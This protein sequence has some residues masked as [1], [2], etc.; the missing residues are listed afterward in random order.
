M[1]RTPAAKLAER[2]DMTRHTVNLAWRTLPFFTIRLPI[3]PLPIIA[4][5]SHVQQPLMVTS[6]L[7]NYTLRNLPHRYT[8]ADA[9]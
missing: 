8:I 9:D 5:T 3:R 4:R 2:S 1:H 6:I 7:A